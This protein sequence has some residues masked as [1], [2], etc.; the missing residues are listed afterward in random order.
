MLVYPVFIM[1]SR[2]LGSV[3]RRSRWEQAT[4]SPWY[5]LPAMAGTYL[6]RD[7]PSASADHGMEMSGVAVATPASDEEAGPSPKLPAANGDHSSPLC[8]Q[9][10]R[11]RKE[12]RAGASSRNTLC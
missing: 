11:L 9:R 4:A 2:A 12:A 8:W 1:L 3:G 5:N 6:N 10:Q 7:A